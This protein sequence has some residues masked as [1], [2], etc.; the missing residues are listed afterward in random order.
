MKIVVNVLMVSLLAA[1]FGQR[2]AAPDAMLRPPVDQYAALPCQRDVAATL[3]RLIS[4]DDSTHCRA[5][6]AAGDD[7]E[8]GLSQRIR[9]TL[10]SVLIWLAVH[11]RHPEVWSHT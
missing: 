6:R 9:R 3:A 8:T 7:G 4:K 11:S 5:K 1:L 10:L 2:S